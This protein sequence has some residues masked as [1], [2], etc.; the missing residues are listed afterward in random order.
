[1]TTTGGETPDTVALL[2]RADVLIDLDR[3]AQARETLRPV[4]AED[5]DDPF[6]LLMLARC[7]LGEGE[8]GDGLHLAE[9]VLAVRPGDDQAHRIAALCN[10]GL[11]RVDAARQHADA[12]VAALPTSWTGY[13]VR[14]QVDLVTGRVDDVSVAAA[15]RAVGLAPQEPSTH[16]ILG[17]VRNAKV[18]TD[19][20]RAALQEVLRLDPENADALRGLGE[21]ST[22]RLELHDAVRTYRRAAA[23]RPGDPRIGRDLAAV[24]RRFFT[25]F[26]LLLLA[27]DGI[28]ILLRNV[29]TGRIFFTALISVLL[30]RTA[31]RFRRVLGEGGRSQR[32]AI[33]RATPGSVIR[34]TGLAL[35]LVTFWAGA[36]VL[37][38]ARVPVHL[39]SAGL[40]VGSAVLSGLW[41]F[42]LEVWRQARAAR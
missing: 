13:V 1:M 26:S 34:T 2:E 6:A 33:R 18:D 25:V 10:A 3:Y 23:L 35:A 4:I 5:P 29:G 38:G 36:F 30:F 14:A 24:V 39:A 41:R 9:Q 37:P 31:R 40:V 19:A 8:V 27:A 42:V 15:E 20:A 28:G 17:Q 16:L 7:A 32:R 12:A 11:R 21:V 22:T